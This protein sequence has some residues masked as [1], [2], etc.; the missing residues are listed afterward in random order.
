MFHWARDASKVAL[1]H[2]FVVMSSGE[3]GLVDVQWQTP[4]LES[5][6]ALVVGRDRYLDDLPLYL[7]KPSPFPGQDR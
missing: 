5:L 3:G 4:H 7:E 2:L 1:F 6:G